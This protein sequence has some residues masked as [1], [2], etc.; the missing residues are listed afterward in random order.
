[1]EYRRRSEYEQNESFQSSDMPMWSYMSRPTPSPPPLFHL[2]RPSPRCLLAT[3]FFC[4]DRVLRAHYPREQDSGRR[5]RFLSVKLPREEKERCVRRWW[6]S[7]SVVSNNVC[8]V[9]CNHVCH[10][11][12]AVQRSQTIFWIIHRDSV[13]TL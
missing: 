4:N 1:M 7:C 9:V 3:R 12:C 11:V 2:S 6:R 10:N 8:Y 13:G 5:A